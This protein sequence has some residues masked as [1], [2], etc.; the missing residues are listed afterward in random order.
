MCMFVILLVAILLTC[1]FFSQML[2]LLGSFGHLFVTFAMNYHQDVAI[3]IN[4]QLPL[5]L[6]MPDGKQ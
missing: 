5:T 2:K 6:N 1:D 3:Y 4:R